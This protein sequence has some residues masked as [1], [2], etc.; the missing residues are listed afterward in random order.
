MKKVTLSIALIFCLILN[1]NAQNY[2]LGNTP[3][4]TT[5]IVLDI[6]GSAEYLGEGSTDA[7]DVVSGMILPESGILT[8]GKKSQMKLSWKSQAVV[9]SKKGTYSLKNEALKL[10]DASLNAPVLDEFLVEL[11]AASGFGEPS[12]D[13]GND[14]SSAKKENKGTLQEINIIMP[15]RGIVPM[16]LITFSWA[17][18]SSDA[19]FRLNVYKNADQPAIFSALTMKNSFTLDVSQLSLIEGAE[20]SWQVENV[21][22]STIKSEASSITFGEKDQ[23][24]EVIR[25]MLSDREYSYSDPWLKILREAHALQKENLIYATN[26]K[27]KQGL[28][29]F[30]D[31]ITIKK[32]YAMFLNNNGLEA[33]ADQVFE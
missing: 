16:D 28:K 17:G 7:Q 30:N 21:S 22:D 24:L 33:L 12:G 1:S 14:S 3:S 25:G 6:E 11:G 20:Y 5:F 31:N 13:G 4:L 15:I 9:L 23:D 26:E 8:L 10:A 32:M 27:Y 29:E 18:L 19:G 2:D